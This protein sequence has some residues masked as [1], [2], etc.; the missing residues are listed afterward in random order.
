[1]IC[2]SEKALERKGESHP[3][4]QRWSIIGCFAPDQ[5]VKPRNE[6]SKGVQNEKTAEERVGVVL[7]PGIGRCSK[8]VNA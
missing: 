2:R 3:L 8:Y 6:Q 4:S 5:H 1:M 7:L